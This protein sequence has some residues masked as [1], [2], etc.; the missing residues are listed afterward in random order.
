MDVAIQ[1]TTVAEAN[2]TRGENSEFNADQIA[3]SISTTS[4]SSGAGLQEHCGGN[5]ESGESHSGRCEPSG[6]RGA[7]DCVSTTTTGQSSCIGGQQSS[8]LNG[9]IANFPAWGYDWLNRITS[10]T[11]KMNIDLLAAAQ[12]KDDRYRLLDRVSVIIQKI[13]RSA[14]MIKVYL[15]LIGAMGNSSQLLVAISAL[16]GAG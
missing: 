9:E 15:A 8:G 1:Q 3:T 7:Q 16:T 5:S 2:G 13:V 11:G 12:Y 14:I 6:E 4:L 10:E